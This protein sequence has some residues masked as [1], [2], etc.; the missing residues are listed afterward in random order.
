MSLLVPFRSDNGRR[1]ETWNW[2]RQYWEAELPSAQIV[3][4]HS[5]VTPFCKT[6]A[7][8][9]AAA[10]ADGDVYVI[11]DA[12]CYIDG[13]VIDDCANAIRAA[14]TA[15]DRLWYVPYRHFYRFTDAASRF[16]LTADP[17]LPPRFFA[18]APPAMMLMAHPDASTGMASGTNT[19]HWYGA[20]IQVM[21][22]EAFELL[23]GMDERFRGWGGEDVAFFHA[24]DVLY[25]KHKTTPNGVIHLWHPSIGGVSVANRQ[26]AGQAGSGANGVLSKRYGMAVGD[27]TRMKALVAEAR[28]FRQSPIASD[29]DVS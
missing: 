25:R 9:D 4:G 3:L 23:G 29:R 21:P 17:V 24:L 5:S 28:E 27:V 15:G 18:A 16:V 22:R 26:W 11:L 10:H 14:R 19:A 1:L 20:L 13:V 2:L 6:A 8:N 7:V 12:D